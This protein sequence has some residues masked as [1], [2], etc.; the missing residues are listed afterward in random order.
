MDGW[1]EIAMMASN[2]LAI[3]LLIFILQKIFSMG[4]EITEIKAKVKYLE[5]IFNHGIHGK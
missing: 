4:S 2:G 3:S 1:A 5:K